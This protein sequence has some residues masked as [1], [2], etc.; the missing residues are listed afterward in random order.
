[1]DLD[2]CPHCGK[3]L[4]IASS[5]QGKYSLYLVSYSGGTTHERFKRAPLVTH[6]CYTLAE[7]RAEMKR[8]ASEYLKIWSHEKCHCSVY[9]GRTK[10]FEFWLHRNEDVRPQFLRRS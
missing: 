2:V 5:A 6:E 3:S 8:E 7:A 1:M 9:K 10:V 4:N